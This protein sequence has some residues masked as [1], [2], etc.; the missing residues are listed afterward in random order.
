M[1]VIHISRQQTTPGDIFVLFIYLFLKST[2]AK[3]LT[4]Q[5]GY[6]QIHNTT[7]HE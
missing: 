4:L 6:I 1:V 3:T 5:C 7:K 2:S